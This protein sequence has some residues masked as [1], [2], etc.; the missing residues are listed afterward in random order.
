M[1]KTQK[2][3]IIIITILGAFMIVNQSK[4]GSAT[5]PSSVGDPL[6]LVVVKDSHDFG[7]EVFEALK[8]YLTID[9]GPSPQEENVLKLMEIEKGAL[10]G[11]FK[12]HQNLLIISKASKFSIKQTK[13]L[14]AKD[15]VVIFL[16][17]S[18]QEELIRHKNKVL[19]VARRIIDIDRARLVNKFKSQNNIKIN[20]VIQKNHGIQMWF[21]KDF[22]VAHIDTSMIWLRRETPKPAKGF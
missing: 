8:S 6:E 12:R 20:D 9:I 1:T 10:K 5:L 14:F 21:P 22:F 13:D 4:K 3:I 15:Q 11:V 16:E 17:F 7:E 19:E 18:D 2:Y